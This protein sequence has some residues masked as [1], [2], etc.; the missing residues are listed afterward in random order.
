MA[1]GYGKASVGAVRMESEG[2]GKDAGASGEG[3]YV[4]ASGVGCRGGRGMSSVWFPGGE[5]EQQYVGGE[6]A[7]PGVSRREHG[8]ER[9]REERSW[10]GC[11]DGPVVCAPRS[12]LGTLRTVEWGG[13]CRDVSANASVHAH[14]VLAHVGRKGMGIRTKEN[15]GLLCGVMLRAGVERTARRRGRGRGR[16]VMCLIFL[17]NEGYGTDFFGLCVF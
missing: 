12:V 7:R 11:V 8:R 3:V 10:C 1:V 6:S 14:R 16:V 17:C 5:R 4:F 9:E 2:R 13:E 15:R